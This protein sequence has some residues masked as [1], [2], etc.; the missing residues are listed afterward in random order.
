[1]TAKQKNR[2]LFLGLVIL[3][4]AAYQFSFKK[5]FE[6][7]ASIEQLEKDRLELNN[8][9]GKLRLLQQQNVYLDSILGSN[10]VSA[11]QS[12]QQNLLQKV[13]GLREQHKVKILSLEE[14]HEAKKDGAIV[15][16]YTIEVKGDFR[17]LMLFSSNLEKQRLGKL[18]SVDFVK[19]MNY[20]TR[21]RELICKIILQRLSK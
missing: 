14:P 5:T 1:M 15:E 9:G 21:R 11:D 20:K 4:F 7:G 6:L 10:N 18:S 19:K 3:F 12:F 16:S 8:A 17:N 2:A 13:D